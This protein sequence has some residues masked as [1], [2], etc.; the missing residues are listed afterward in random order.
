MSTSGVGIQGGVTLCWWVFSL[1]LITK[2]WANILKAFPFSAVTCTP[3]L[4][5]TLLSSLLITDKWLTLLFSL[6]SFSWVEKYIYYLLNSRWS[7]S[8]TSLSYIP[9][10]GCPKTKGHLQET[11]IHQFLS[12][13]AWAYSCFEKDLN[14]V[15]HQP[16]T[17]DRKKI[18]DLMKD[19]LGNTRVL[20]KDGRCGAQPAVQQKKDFGWEGKTTAAHDI[21]FADGKKKLIWVVN[22]NQIILALNKPWENSWNCLE[23]LHNDSLRS[24]KLLFFFR[25]AHQTVNHGSAQTSALKSSSTSDRSCF[26]ALS[27]FLCISWPISLLE[28]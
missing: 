25:L 18:S 8:C 5:I 11:D 17:T 10:P 13:L 24:I 23:F 3:G 1:E 20:E 12:N 7:H 22:T 15:L 27:T 16:I 2:L 19:Q 4:V 28:G 26:H 21:M 14:D 9:F 6:S